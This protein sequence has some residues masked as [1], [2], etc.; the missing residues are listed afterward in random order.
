MTVF[1]DSIFQ[2]VTELNEVFGKTLWEGDVA[3]LQAK[4][5]GLRKKQPC[6]H[7]EF[8]ASRIVRQQ[9]SVVEALQSVIL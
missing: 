7:L 1:G 8:G 5:R 2:E 6:R 3:R 9:G 4:E